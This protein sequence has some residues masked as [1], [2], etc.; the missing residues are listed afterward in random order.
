[1]VKRMSVGMSASASKSRP[2]RRLMRNP[3]VGRQDVQ[4]Q[5]EA[6]LD[7]VDVVSFD[8]FDTLI[9]R[10]ELFCPKDVFYHVRDVAAKRQIEIG[11]FVTARVHAEETARVR[12]RGYHKE[13]IALEDIYAELGRRTGLT[14]TAVNAL[15]QIELD[16]ERSRLIALEAGKRLFATTLRAG[17]RIVIISDTYFSEPFLAEIIVE[18]GYAARKIYASSTYGKTKIQ[19]SLYD[20]VLRDLS[21]VP[22]KILHVGDN[23][24]SDVTRALGRGMRALLFTVPHGE[25]K[26]RYGIPDRPSGNPVISA[27]LKHLSHASAPESEPPDRQAVLAHTARHLSLLYFGFAAW[28][29]DQVRHHPCRRI[30]FAAREGLVL[31]RFFDLVAARAGLHIDSRYLYVSRAALY[32]SLVVADPEMAR[33]LFCHHWDHLTFAEALR[34]LSLDYEE[35]G[36]T[37]RTHGISYP[38][39]PLNAVTVPKLAGIVDGLWPV[40]RRKN[41]GH[42]QLLTE[43]LQQ[44]MVLA[45]EPVAF[46]DIG[47]HGTLQYCLGKLLRHVGMRTGVSGY[48]LGVFATPPGA[49]TD[50]HAKGF[51]INQNEPQSITALV[52]AG[53][54]LIE[55][56]HSAGHGSVLGYERKDGRI[57]PILEMNPE[58]DRQ[59]L[60]LI[61]P[62]QHQ[63]FDHI[64]EQLKGFEDASMTA[65]DPAVIARAALR[66]VYAPTAAEAATFG[67]LRI[68]TD[69]G[70]PLKSITGI[71]EHDVKTMQGETLPDGTLPM[72][73][74]GLRALTESSRSSE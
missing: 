9:E 49:G 61:E 36:A 11:E 15:M 60:E 58:Q 65:P 8:L 6:M 26:R 22:N 42:I 72:W 56:F 39:L 74:P 45:D 23:P 21:T 52:R 38:T 14:S 41:E 12:A 3:S 47:W 44:E 62:I 35:V 10:R 31:K 13:E 48:Y 53:P 66:V 30:Y 20:V 54:S 24:M 18:H 43:Y 7:V 63:A 50:F 16:C 68:A 37:L 4:R 1:M 29:V 57:A 71:V 55:L 25:W 34:R 2:G 67:R 27:M 64:A 17:K 51:L 69:F 70:A 59:F 28:L 46:V 5:F 73:R 32:P 40:L 33:R 19:G